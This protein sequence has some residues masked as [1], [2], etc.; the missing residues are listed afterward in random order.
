MEKKI[1]VV[2][3][4]VENFYSVVPHELKT[5]CSVT[6]R[7]TQATLKHFGVETR[8]LPCQVWVATADHN[9][10][11]GFVGKVPVNGKWDGHVVCSGD[12]FIVDAAL[13][14]FNV[15]FG[16]TVPSIVAAEKFAVPTQVISRVNLDTASRLWW[17]MPPVSD[18]IDL[19]VPQ[20]PP[21]VIAK[22]SALLIERLSKLPAIATER[23]EQSEPQRRHPF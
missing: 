6:S 7:I 18:D 13:R 11:V 5:Y 12:G 8:L 17:Y 15:E 10:V 3:A 9:Y 23:V 1:L 14:H 22:Y 4:L 19:N 20:E 21:E 2:D 16:L